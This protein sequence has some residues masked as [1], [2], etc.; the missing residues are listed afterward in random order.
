MLGE[1]RIA[2]YALRFIFQRGT[3]LTWAVT[4]GVGAFVLMVVLRTA[5]NKILSAMGGLSF[6]HYPSIPVFLSMS[7]VFTLVTYFMLGVIRALQ[8]EQEAEHQNLLTKEAQ[9]RVLTVNLP[10]G[11]SIRSKDGKYIY[12]NPAF[13]KIT[14]YELN[15]I[16]DG[17][18][19]YQEAYSDKEYGRI[20]VKNWIKE[21]DSSSSEEVYSRVYTVYCKN[22]LKKIVNFRQV[23]L[24]DDTMIV[25]DDVTEQ[26]HAEQA[27]RILVGSSP[28]G[29]FIVQEKKFKM[30][31]P[32]F[33]AI[34]EYDRSELL[35]RDSLEIVAPQYRSHVRR[36]AVKMLK[37]AALRERGEKEKI[38]PYEFKIVAKSGELKTVLETVIPIYCR[39]DKATL[40]FFMDITHQKRME[41]NLA[42]TEKMQSIGV[43]AGGIAH[44]FNNILTAILGNISIADITA[45]LKERTKALNHAAKACEQARDLTKQLL[46]FSRGGEPVKEMTSIANLLKECSELVFRG[47]SCDFEIDASPD[48]WPTQLDTGQISQV[49]NNLLINAIHASP[50]G[51]IIKIGVENAQIGAHTALALSPGDYIK[52]SISDPGAGIPR[53]VLLRIFDP[54]FTTKEKGT[55]LG[56]V[57]AY[58]IVKSHGGCIS[59]NSKVGK[60]S[61]FE[62]YLP[63]S[64]EGVGT[65]QS[66]KY[67]EMKRG[68]GERMLVMDDDQSVRATIS[69]MLKKLNFEVAEVEN[70]EQ[71]L[72]EYRN[73]MNEGSPFFAVIIDLTIRGGMGGRETVRELLEIDPLAKA[74]VSSGYSDDPIMSDFQKYGFA[75]CIQKPYRIEA[76]SNEIH[77]LIHRV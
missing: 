25:Y 29:I 3:K 15:E 21:L 59:V 14:G 67:R 75:G 54:F 9:F 46:I 33:E 38:Q 10:V 19:W 45:D 5:S 2:R 71:A 61:T 32:G 7:L 44:D 8:A 41:A 23:A 70:G 37:R 60:G 30:V 52:V 76:L 12:I 49:V 55:G 77:R 4:C 27:L 68:N 53:E 26:S 6:V 48:V 47:T 56:L 57:S 16:P 1:L 58:S 11:V 64:P 28:I 18:N 51:S 36:N 72:T 62:F 42:L 20:A 24:G 34:T 39:G 43:L 35:N 22:G 31:N 74:I 17:E 66:K 50:D 65:L 40:G 73:A 69:K 63:A 13:T